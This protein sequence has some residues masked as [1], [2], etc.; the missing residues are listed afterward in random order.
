MNQISH[1]SA[2]IN[3]DEEHLRLLGN[4]HLLMAGLT[5]LVLVL[6]TL[7]PLLVG[8]AFFTFLGLPPSPPEKLVFS[9]LL[10]G[11]I[12]AIYGFNGWSLRNR[13][14]RV[15][16]IILSCIECLTSLPYGMIMG[17]SAILVLRRESVRELFRAQLTSR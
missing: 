12:S 14:H 5:A 8:P 13:Q 7:L 9:L 15:S 3:R 16:C 2:L 10:L 1:T 6:F 4:Y 11:I 17:I